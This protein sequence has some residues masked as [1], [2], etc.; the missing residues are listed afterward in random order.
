[1]ACVPCYY[2]SVNAWECD[3]NA[4]LNVRFFAEKVAQ[5]WTVFFGDYPQPG[6]LPQLESQH[7]R[8]VREALI[9][10]PLRIECAVLPG[11]A[12]CEVLSL[13]YNNLTHEPLAGFLSRFAGPVPEGAPTAE[14]PD[15][16]SPRGLDPDDPYPDPTDHQA[17][18]AVGFQ[19]M[20]RGVVAT[21]ECD[22]RGRL[23]PHNYLGRLSDGMPNLWAFLADPGDAAPRLGGAALE[24][25]LQLF[26]PLARDDVFRHVSGIRAVANKTQHMVHMIFNETTGE[27]S[28]RAEVIGVAMDL[29]SRRAVPISAERRE[30]M[31]RLMLR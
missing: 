14:A 7:I 12:R 2:G 25:R 19:T 6:G 5:A 30:R 16:A 20:G 28:A 1:V 31:N 23:L 29:S 9:A 15:W 8:F 17:A 10:T 11:T 24:Y 27:L 3:E 21:L 26:A 22:A 13:V 18:A 4:H